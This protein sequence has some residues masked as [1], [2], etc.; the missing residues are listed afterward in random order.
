[1]A[2]GGW[3]G[4]TSE[5][6]ELGEWAPS[7]AAAPAF[8]LG[9]W[10][11]RTETETDRERGTARGRGNAP[12]AFALGPLGAWTRRTETDR[13]RGAARGRGNGGRPKTPPAHGNEG[14]GATTTGGEEGVQC[15]I[16]LEPARSPR[17]FPHP[18]CSHSYCAACLASLRGRSPSATCPQ[19]RRPATDNSPCRDDTGLATPPVTPVS[20]PTVSSRQLETER[21]QRTLRLLLEPL[22]LPSMSRQLERPQNA[23]ITQTGA[24]YHISRS[25]HGLRNATR[26]WHGSTQGKEPCKLCIGVGARPGALQATGGSPRQVVAAD[27]AQAAFRHF[28]TRTGKAFHRSRTCAGLR[29]ATALFEATGASPTGANRHLQP[30]KL[31]CQ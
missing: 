13:E 25:C 24:K 15:A 4:S 21:R 28:T 26:I 18:D 1:M 22:D 7:P 5:R 10:T 8:A 31:C 9:A 11:R 14:V 2:L 17:P 6:D 19:C 29:R 16:C 3:A 12:P 20:R 27:S 30:C 23:L